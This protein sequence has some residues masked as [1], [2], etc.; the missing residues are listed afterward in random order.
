MTSPLL[1]GIWVPL[2]TPFTGTSAQAVD[3]AGLARLVASL[4]ETGIAGLVVCG[5]TGEAAML[6]DQERRA[7]LDT[8]LA[9]GAGLPVLMG[10]SGVATPQVREDLLRW[11]E[12]P[13]AGFLVSPPYYVKPS[14]AGIADHYAALADASPLPIVLYDIPGRTGVRIA[15]DTMLALAAHERIVGV[16]DCSGDLDH[17]QAV[18]SDGRLAVLCGDD[19]RIFASL[20]L[21]GAGA[22]AASA[23]LHPQRFVELQQLVDEGRLAEARALWRRLWPLTTALF[24][25]PSPGPLKAALA[26]L[27]GLRNQLRP[28]MTLASAATEALVA[29]ALEGL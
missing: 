29:R 10:L 6:S 19:H 17:L 23:H 18:L 8:T 3:H 1:R 7:V 5:S 4:R 20:C 11:A 2:V 22:I 15:T 9:A 21:G 16:K 26:P 27:H 14:Q 25:E 28:P 24:E 12:Q 13:V